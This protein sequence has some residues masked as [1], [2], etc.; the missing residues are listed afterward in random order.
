MREDRR[1]PTTRLL[2]L[3]T[4]RVSA[5]ILL[6]ATILG[7]VAAIALAGSPRTTN[8]PTAGLPASAQST[9]VARLQQQL[10]SSRV[11]P[12]LIVYSR[13]AG[14]LTARDR[15]VI[16]SQ[17]PALRALALG[18]RVSPMQIAPD[19]R[20]AIA[21]VP[22][23]SDLDVSKI[24]SLV[25][26]IRGVARH[27]LPAGLRAQ[28]TGGAGFIADL[29][30]AFSG[31]SVSLLLV[32]VI[33]VALLLL[34]TYRSP[35]LWIVPLVVVALADQL[36]GAIIAVVSRHIDVTFSQASTGIVE[37]LIFGAGTD[38]ALLLIARYREEL[39]RVD[40]RREA[41]RRA[42]VAAGPAIAASGVTVIAAL[43]T[44]LFAVLGD[45]KAIGVAGAIGIATALLFGLVVLPAALVIFPRGL[46][47]PLVPRADER[48]RRAN[49]TEGRVWRRIGSGTARRPWPVV[50]TCLLAL[51]IFGAGL[52]GVRV[53]LS[54]ADT[55]RTR[56]ESID[57]LKA[58]SR[59]FPAG[60]AD[61]VA[62]ITTPARVSAV[63]GAIRHVAGVAS[64][65]QG[66]MA[67][68][69]AQID[70]T[71]IAA[72]D[73]PA[74]YDAIRAMRAAVTAIPG[75]SAYVGG[76]VATTL[77][78]ETAAEHDLA[79]I[80][81][82]IL[83]VVFVVLIVLLR[84]LVAPVVLILTVVLSF[85]AALGAANWSFGHL[86]GLAGLASQVPLLSFLFLVA[87]GIDYNI[88]LTTRAREESARVGTRLGIIDALAVTGGVI[89]SAGI[90]L[91][92][93]FTV[94]GIL[95]VIVLT[96]L[97]IIVGFGVLLDTLLVRTIL[98]PAIVQVLGDRFWSPRRVATQPERSHRHA[99][100][101]GSA[102]AAI[103]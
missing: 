69:I 99:S 76:T 80:A 60:A 98:V 3:I 61:P 6:F 25:T 17:L 83:L 103:R 90:L 68:T 41:M 64:V 73:T 28:V 46:F 97:G 44:L 95:P 75:A 87:L 1:V 101:H 24:D 47:W 38:Y 62:V 92:S 84:A 82:L 67:G 5:L 85:F 13:M 31:A 96:E 50:V 55:F 77:D 21:A 70:V 59:S 12:A 94:L 42:V 56:A 10:P 91:A 33:V 20:A 52:T 19:G 48:G 32:T 34:I 43:L 15:Q 40:E 54:Q 35:I 93:V 63:V 27:G 89:T 53:G 51:G 88:F 78:T 16:A 45:D 9:I 36:A 29:D 58:V 66:E 11:I 86:L 2:A 65:A 37:V 102:E 18:H 71:L 72:P 74:S 14:T 100:G 22:L 30:N 79:V 57:G 7:S 23:A 81:P 4:G 49:E 26:S 8:D 39:R